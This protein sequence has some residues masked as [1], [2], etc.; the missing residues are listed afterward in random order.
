[1]DAADK[2]R[3]IRALADQMEGL[4]ANLRDV[5]EAFVSDVK[6]RANPRRCQT[7]TPP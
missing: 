2:I 3:S 7:S 6:T 1:M 5:C 4:A